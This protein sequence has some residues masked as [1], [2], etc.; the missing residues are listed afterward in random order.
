MNKI[1]V[2]V[3]GLHVLYTVRDLVAIK[4]KE[5]AFAHNF[6]TAI[7]HITHHYHLI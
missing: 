1:N 7:F 4:D 3:L 6:Y 2:V 5:N